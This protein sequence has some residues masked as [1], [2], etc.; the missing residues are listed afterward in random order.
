MEK[1][2]GHDNGTLICL[3][4]AANTAFL[5]RNVQF[6]LDNQFEGS[7]YGKTDAAIAETSTFFWSLQRPGESSRLVTYLFTLNRDQNFRLAAVQ[8]QQLARILDSNPARLYFFA[9]GTWNIEQ[10]VILAARSSFKLSLGHLC[11]AFDD[12]G[13]AFVEAI[14]NR[15][16]SFGSLSMGFFL[17]A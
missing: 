10:S 16:S 17:S 12:D 11:N 2:S 4:D 6:F 9:G 13:T 14:M 8:P 15:R 7:I 1:R 5:D 3:G